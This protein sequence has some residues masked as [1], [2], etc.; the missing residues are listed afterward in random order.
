MANLHRLKTNLIKFKAQRDQQKRLL[1]KARPLSDYDLD[2][3][4]DGLIALYCEV[5]NIRGRDLI[6]DASFSRAQQCEMLGSYL[7]E[8]YNTQLT[9]NIMSN[10]MSYWKPSV[11]MVHGDTVQVSL[12][13]TVIA[14]FN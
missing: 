6:G 4:P 13:N 12:G 7:M 5:L 11:K 14:T 3:P 1:P 2:G 8:F 10:R 9:L